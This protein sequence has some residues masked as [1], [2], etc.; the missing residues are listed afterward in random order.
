MLNL[1]LKV[2]ILET[3]QNQSDFALH[4]K[5]HESAVSSVVRGR[6][7]LSQE[8]QEEWAKALG[9]ETKNIFEN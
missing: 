6:R 8:S 2:K 3:F 9:C 1:K 7:K 4:M 5:L